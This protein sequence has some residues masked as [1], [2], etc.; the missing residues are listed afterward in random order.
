MPWK[1]FFVGLG[2]NH[3]DKFV[4]NGGHELHGTVDI[5]GAKNSVVG[6]LPAT[7]LAEGLCRIENIPNISDV[8]YM[9]E[10]LAAMGADVR[11]VNKNTYEI[12]TTHLNSYT[13]PYD[14]TKHL[15]LIIFWAP[16]SAAAPRRALPCRAAATSAGS[17]PST[18]T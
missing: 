12:D 9:L 7:L 11:A 17:A 2:V 14:L 5:S 1:P 13:V 10:M 4:I 6:I 18:S 16:C 15:R 8:S 3:L